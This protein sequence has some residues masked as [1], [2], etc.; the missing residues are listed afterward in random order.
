MSGGKRGRNKQNPEQPKPGLAVSSSPPTKRRFLVKCLKILALAL[1]SLATISA[2]LPFLQPPSV[3]TPVPLESDDPY[4]IPY[5]ITNESLV[6]IFHVKYV[7]EI[8]DIKS[9][10]GNLEIKGFGYEYAD[11]TRGVLWP[12]GRMTARCHG[13]GVV[14]P[15][16][17]AEAKVSI[18][19][20]G[21][22]PFPRKIVYEFTGLFDPNTGK[23]FRWTP[24]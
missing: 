15:M 3:Q 1:S 17:K 21:L 24:K 7:C 11:A 14:V 10:S 2:L 12:K 8:A 13:A 22:W 6:P 20:Y 23:L 16:S 5:E 4:S 9:L 19:Y 18:S